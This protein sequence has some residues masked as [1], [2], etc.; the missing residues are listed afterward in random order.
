M[1]GIAGAILAGSN[2]FIEKSKV[3]KRRH[4]GDL[5]S[6]YPYIVNA[7]Y[8]MNTHMGSMREYWQHALTVAERFNKI[9]G[10][11]T[12]PK[13]P[14]CNMF[15]AYFDVP[16][17][18]MESI[19]ADIIEKYDLC[20]IG[21]IKAIAH[22]SCKSEFSFGNSFRSIPQGHLEDALNHLEVEFKK[23]KG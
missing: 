20:L 17:E 16:K 11:R 1:R 22:S 19:F 2:E 6:L 10:I 8:S 14:V 4:G 21:N 15:H 7:K 23:L 3:W 18:T 5:I 12:I 9:S 13:I